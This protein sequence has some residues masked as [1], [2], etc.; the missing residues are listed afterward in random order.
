MTLRLSIL[1]LFADRSIST[2]G[3]MRQMPNVS[4]GVCR[5]R[6][7]RMVGAGELTRSEGGRYTITD[8]GRLALAEIDAEWVPMVAD[9]PRTRVDPVFR[10]PPGTNAHRRPKRAARVSLAEVETMGFRPVRKMRGG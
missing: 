8:A 5:S 9:K 7:S 2:D 6:L 4:E 10:L 3:I 1:R